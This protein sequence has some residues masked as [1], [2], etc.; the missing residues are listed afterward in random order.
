[1]QLTVRCLLLSILIILFSVILHSVAGI[2]AAI[3]WLSAAHIIGC[4]TIGPTKV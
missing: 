2:V 4:L 1:M 3:N